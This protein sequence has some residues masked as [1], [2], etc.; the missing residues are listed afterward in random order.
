VPAFTAAHLVV[1]QATDFVAA[2]LADR[3]ASSGCDSPD[4]RPDW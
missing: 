3:A 2:V 1:E 4:V